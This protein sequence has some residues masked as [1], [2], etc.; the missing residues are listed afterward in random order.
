MFLN[1][2]NTIFISQPIQ[3]GGSSLNPSGIKYF[4]AYSTD[5]M[6]S[7]LDIID[8]PVALYVESIGRNIHDDDSM[9]IE[10]NVILSIDMSGD[11][12]HDQ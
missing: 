1:T 11:N 8:T 6:E 2:G 7:G 9:D 10:P 5:V 4:D 12:A 3:G